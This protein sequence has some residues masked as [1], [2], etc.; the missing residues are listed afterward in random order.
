MSRLVVVSNRVAA[1]QDAARAG[2]LSVAMRSALRAGPALW[3]GWSGERT[4]EFTGELKSYQVDDIDVVTVDLEEADY[5]EYY[6]GY[7][8]STL[9]PVFH[10]RTD[11]AAYD[12]SFDSGYARVNRRFAAALAPLL[13][14]DD[15]IWVHDYH[16]IPLGRELRKLGVTNPIGFFLHIPWPAPQLFTTL[17]RHRALVESMF[18]YDLV[19]LH[20][21]AGALGLGRAAEL[22]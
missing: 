16:L 12:R 8:N 13:R 1:E 10:F 6:N 5:D 2:G 4:P 17:P 7:A 3:F 15:L 9:W 18:A 21:V 19:G 14:P 11:L 20:A 22:Q